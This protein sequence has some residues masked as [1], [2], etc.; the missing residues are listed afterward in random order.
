MFAES[1][2]KTSHTFRI[3]TTPPNHGV[4]LA[5]F[6]IKKAISVNF[7]EHVSLTRNLFSP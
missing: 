4:G 6:T 3:R 1:K 7:H 2:N 5:S